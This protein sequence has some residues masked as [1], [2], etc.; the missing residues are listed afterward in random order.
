MA[1]HK[2]L[3]LQLNEIEQ[4]YDAKFR[5]VF[6]A[7]RELMMTPPESRKRKLGFLVKNEQRGTEED[8]AVAS[9]F[10]EFRK[11]GSVICGEWCRSGYDRDLQKLSRLFY[12]SHVTPTAFAF[13]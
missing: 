5:V 2:D 9:M 6:D 10:P 8:R 4:K 3:V 12:F 7:I 11:H 1:T 13:S